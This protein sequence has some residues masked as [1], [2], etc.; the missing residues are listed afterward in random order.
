MD[1]FLVLC[2]PLSDGWLLSHGIVTSAIHFEPLFKVVLVEQI[3]IIG[4][5]FPNHELSVLN[6]FFQLEDAIR[7]LLRLLL[8][9]RRPAIVLGVLTSAYIQVTQENHDCA[10]SIRIQVNEKKR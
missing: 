3:V 8:L 10:I 7:C 6:L 2:V 1:S 4:A 9:F 5:Q